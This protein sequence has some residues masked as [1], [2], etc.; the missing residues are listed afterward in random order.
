MLTSTFA[1][2]Y[3]WYLNGSPIVGA[4]SQTYSIAANGSYTVVTSNGA[5]CEAF[6]DP[7]VVTTTEVVSISNHDD[8]N[9]FPNPYYDFTSIQ[10]NT[11]EDAFVLA[12]VF[13]VLGEKIQT[14]VKSEL[15]AGNHSFNFG[16]KQ[17]G[18]S[19]GIYF[20]RICINNQVSVLK[21]VEND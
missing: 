19:S 14:I 5:G 11:S 1:T 20:V 16:A 8:V 9:A 13:S 2:T 4:T 3:Q 7:L 18:F 6:S 15:S 12:E 17:L 10:I 21:I